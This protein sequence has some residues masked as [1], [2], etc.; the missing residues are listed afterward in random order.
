MLTTQFVTLVTKE[1][2]RIWY[3]PHMYK[4]C[5]I[6]VPHCLDYG[7]LC[8]ESRH[9]PGYIEHVKVEFI[10]MLQ[11]FQQIAFMRLVVVD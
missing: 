8:V 11:M 10:Y 9:C 2:G 4:H 5:E 6:C 1:Q 3:L 7:Y